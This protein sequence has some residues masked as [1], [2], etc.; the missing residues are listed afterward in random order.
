[1]QFTW[2]KKKS[3]QNTSL[4]IGRTLCFAIPVKIEKSQ[5]EFYIRRCIDSIR[6]LYPDVAIVILLSS[7]TSPLVFDDINIFQITNPYYGIM[8]CFYILDKYKCAEYAYI[9]H[10]TMVVLKELPTPEKPV[11]FLYDFKEPTL[12][13]EHYDISY[14]KLLSS[15]DYNSLFREKVN[16][17]FGVT[18]GIQSKIIQQTGVL[19]LLTK[20]SN[21]TDGC[22]MERVFSFLCKKN[23]I[24]YDVLC[25]SIFGFMCPWNHPEF[26]KLTLQEIL[27]HKYPT[28]ILKCIVNRQ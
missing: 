23:N 18:M 21:K 13:A 6:R 24:E 12:S 22:A 5:H 28:Y 3:I 11:S 10:D 15:D 14:K 9:I 8:G 27:Q 2:S 20:V 1:M 4:P 17:C 26:C 19:E 16:G 25:G 7:E